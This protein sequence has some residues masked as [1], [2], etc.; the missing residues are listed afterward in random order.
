MDTITN[1][2]IEE[3]DTITNAPLNVCNNKNK[4]IVRVDILI[5]RPVI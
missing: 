2:I 5:Y 1:A 4:V 3:M